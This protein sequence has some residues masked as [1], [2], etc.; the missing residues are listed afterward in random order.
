MNIAREL[1]KCYANVT[2]TLRVW[3]NPALLQDAPTVT[4]IESTS[5]KVS[6][7][8]FPAVTICPRD[9]VDWKKAMEAERDFVPSNNKNSIQLF[10]KLLT[11]LSSMAFAR[12]YEVNFLQNAS[13]MELGGE[14]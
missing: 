10:R 1:R 3:F 12:F 2:N 5:Y 9:R 4:V 8:P 7:I 6:S 14:I 11:T 13:L